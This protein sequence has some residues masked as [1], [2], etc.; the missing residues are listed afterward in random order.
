MRRSGYRRDVGAEA[1]NDVMRRIHRERVLLVGGGRAL[2]MQLAHPAV[3][4]GAAEHSEFVE[5]GLARLRR[6]LDLSMAIVYGTPEQAETAVARIRSVHDRVAGTVD[7]EPYEANDPRLLMWVHATLI[8]SALLVYER[9]VR[10][11]PGP[12]K[13][14]YY[15]ETKRSAR[16]MGIAP[17]IVPQDLDAFEAYVRGMVDG[18]ELRATEDGRRLTAGVLRP[19]LPMVLRP[20][21]EG[22]RLLTLALLPDRI[23]EMF[24]LRAGR[25]SRAALTLAA[26]G[27]RLILPVLPRGV[28]AFSGSRV[29]RGR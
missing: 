20:G 22:V 15:E 5:R 17:E 25:L 26:G 1:A 13:R 10:P 28:R 4:G 24:G 9:F 23:R 6:T 29:A 8:D 16:L 21:A 2:I 18:G 19:P 7:G 14:R 12:L 3:A 27:S 11:L